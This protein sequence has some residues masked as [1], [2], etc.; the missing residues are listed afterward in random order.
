MLL[1]FSLRYR[2]NNLKRK[3]KDSVANPLHSTIKPSPTKSG[4]YV[5]AF[6]EGE[7]LNSPTVLLWV[8]LPFLFIV[9]AP[10]HILVPLNSNLGTSTKCF[11]SYYTGIPAF[12]KAS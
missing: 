3:G 5:K 1:L 10:F 6:T 4:Q 9:H 8:R 2:L 11:G 7:L 12:I